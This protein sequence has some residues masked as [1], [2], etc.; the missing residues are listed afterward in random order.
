MSLT[1]SLDQIIP[2][3]QARANLSDLI[4]KTPKKKLYIITRKNKPTVALVDIKFFEKI[5]KNPIQI[6]IHQ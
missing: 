2:F 4:D 1:V 5:L 6:V 3:S